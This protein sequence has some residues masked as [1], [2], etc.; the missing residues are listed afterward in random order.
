MT[1]IDFGPV[2]LGGNVFGWTADRETSFRILD[3]FVDAG[4]KFIDTADVY[5]AWAPGN[6]G[7]ESETIIGQW[8]R[9]RGHRDRVGIATKVFMLESRPGLS[10]ANIVAAANDSLRRLGVERIELYYAHRDDLTVAQE[11]YLSAFNALVEAGKV[12]EIGTSQF[13]PER[14]VSANQI[15]RER[16]LREFTVSQDQ[17]NLVERDAERTL[18]P[19]LAEL[20]MVEV[21]FYGLARGFLTG[22][23]RTGVSIDSPR[24]EAASSYLARPGADALLDALAAIA[25]EHAVSMGAVALAWLRQQAT[26]AAPIASARSLEQLVGLTESFGLQLSGDE[27]TTLS[28]LR[29]DDN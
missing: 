28:E 8:L 11:D 22:K 15:A 1:D 23:Y 19:T 2:V 3:A 18:L 7:G 5:S 26:V 27:M 21:P 9:S 10:P 4:G 13:A 20:G 6:Q 17:Y 29:L 14:L 16:G 24:A 12:G 25:R